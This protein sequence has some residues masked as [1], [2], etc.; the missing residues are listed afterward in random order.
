MIIESRFGIGGQDKIMLEETYNVLLVLLFLEKMLIDNPPH[1]EQMN[2]IYQNLPE[3][4]KLQFESKYWN[5]LVR[6]RNQ[7]YVLLT[8]ITGIIIIIIIII[9]IS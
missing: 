3:E 8:L 1:Y 7:A 2:Q 9:I 5:D 4:S 6:L